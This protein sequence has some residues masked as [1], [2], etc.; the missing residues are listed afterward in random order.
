MVSKNII[1]SQNKI[2]R[3]TITIIVGTH[4]LLQQ[5]STAWYLLTTPWKKKFLKFF[6]TTNG[7]WR[8]I[9]RVLHAKTL[10]NS[11][12]AFQGHIRSLK[13]MCSISNEISFG[14]WACFSCCWERKKCLWNCK[15]TLTSIWV[16]VFQMYG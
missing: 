8:I 14:T 4:F 7:S 13:V 10:T 3:Q 5:K 1:L 6:E 9:P 16:F 11:V 2:M 12:C 15:E